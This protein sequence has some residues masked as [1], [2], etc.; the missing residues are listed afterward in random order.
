MS[1]R[2]RPQHNYQAL[3]FELASKGKLPTE[4]GLH[5]VYIA[6]DD[7]CGI[8]ADGHCDCDPEVE[9]QGRSYGISWG[10]D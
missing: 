8:W 4:V 5:H 9:V 7:W 6:H 2:R 1:A 3:L 10:T